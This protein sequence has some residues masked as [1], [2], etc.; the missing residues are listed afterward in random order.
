[1][2]TKGKQLWWRHEGGSDQLF[3]LQPENI[4]SRP[5][6]LIGGSLKLDNGDLDIEV[7]IG[8]DVCPHTSSDETLSATILVDGQWLGELDRS[9][10]GMCSS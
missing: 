7:V 1:M 4:A 9:T 3:F 2:T 8:V 10:R 6:L 5:L